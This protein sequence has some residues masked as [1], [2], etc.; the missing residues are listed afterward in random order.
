[1]YCSWIDAAKFL[2]GAA[3]VAIPIIL[4]HARMI[5]TAVM[6]GLSSYDHFVEYS[7]HTNKAFDSVKYFTALICI[8]LYRRIYIQVGK[9]T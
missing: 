5:E 1:L 6:C 3:A 9:L 7:R 4:R 8:H 2:T